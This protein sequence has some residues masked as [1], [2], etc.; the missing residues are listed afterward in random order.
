VPTAL[1]GSAL[2]LDPRGVPQTIVVQGRVQ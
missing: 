2:L 1:R